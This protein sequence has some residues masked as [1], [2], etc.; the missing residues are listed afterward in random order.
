[1]ER[2]F[3][4]ISAKRGQTAVGGA[5]G[6]AHQRDALG[7]M[8]QDGHAY[9]LKN[10]VSFEI[11]SR[12]GQRF[13]PA[14]YD[15]HVR[16]KNASFLQ[17]LVHGKPDA[18]VEAAEHRRIRNVWISSRVEV[19]HLLH[20]SNFT[21]AGHYSRRPVVCLENARWPDRSEREEI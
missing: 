19:E 14:G 11:V 6:V 20:G 12:R 7:A 13:C 16:A 15:D 18:L 2:L 3:L 9:L 10:E 17:E 1:M 8:Q 21:T 5:I 4:R